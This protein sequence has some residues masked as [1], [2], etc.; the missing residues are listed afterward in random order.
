MQFTSNYKLRVLI[1][2][3]KIFIRFATGLVVMGGDPR[4]EVCM[5]ES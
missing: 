4:F 1:Y 3:Y 2:K 5:F